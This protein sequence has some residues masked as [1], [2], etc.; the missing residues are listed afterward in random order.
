MGVGEVD[1]ACGASEARAGA[2]RVWKGGKRVGHVGSVVA[3]LN[4]QCQVC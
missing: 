3:T 4:K 2:A 1:V